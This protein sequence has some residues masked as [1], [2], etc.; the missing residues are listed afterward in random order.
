MQKVLTELITHVQNLGG[1]VVFAS[2]NKLIVKTTKPTIAQAKQ[3]CNFLIR[4][5]HDD[6]RFKCL[7]VSP[8]S[9][10]SWLLLLDGH[11]FGGYMV[12]NAVGV[13]EDSSLSQAPRELPGVASYWNLAEHLPVKYQPIFHELI[14]R[15]IEAP[16]NERLN[17]LEADFALSLPGAGPLQASQAQL[18]TD[19]PTTEHDLRTIVSLVCY[20]DSHMYSKC[21]CRSGSH[22][23][24]T[25]GFSPSRAG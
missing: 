1:Y 2:F 12:E 14:R 7:L 18:A 3:Y 5:I 17:R 16:Y 9:Y 25:R 13:S 20:D 23:F 10:W 22:G 8:T 21:L 11:N 15:L 6:T 4:S 24:Q 19:S